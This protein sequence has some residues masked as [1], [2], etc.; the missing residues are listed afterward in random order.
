MK[1]KLAGFLIDVIL[2]PASTKTLL[3]WNLMWDLITM[4]ACS[5]IH[6]GP[7]PRF[8]FKFIR[9][10]VDD[11]NIKKND[12]KTTIVWMKNILTAFGATTPFS[13]LSGLV[14]TGPCYNMKYIA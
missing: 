11:E 2:S 5:A 4:Y 1:Q 8:V 3:N 12:T 14:W 9:I 10:S 7:M 13:N 6:L